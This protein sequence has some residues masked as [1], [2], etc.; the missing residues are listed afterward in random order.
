MSEFWGYG[1]VVLFHSQI[2]TYISSFIRKY[3]LIQT[4]EYSVSSQYKTS[5]IGMKNQTK[6]NQI[7]TT[8]LQDMKNKDMEKYGLGNEECIL[9][10]TFINSLK[11]DLDRMMT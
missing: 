4:Y 1:D 10:G 8:N 2:Y 6:P 3:L 7:K 5:I 9:L 11:T